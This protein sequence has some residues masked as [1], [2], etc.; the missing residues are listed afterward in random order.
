MTSVVNETKFE[1]WVKKNGSKTATAKL[2]GVSLSCVSR[3]VS[4]ERFPQKKQM[5]AI[6]E[7]SGGYVRPQDIFAHF[8]TDPNA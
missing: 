7:L 3:W 1:R 6:F 2:L 4:R 5:D 8:A